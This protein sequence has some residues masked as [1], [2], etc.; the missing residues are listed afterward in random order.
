MRRFVNGKAKRQSS[1]PF[2]LGKR[3]DDFAQVHGFRRSATRPATASGFAG[4]EESA[5]ESSHTEAP[6]RGGSKKGLEKFGNW[7]GLAGTIAAIALLWRPARMWLVQ[8]VRRHHPAMAICTLV[9]FRGPAVAL[10]P[11]RI[12][13]CSA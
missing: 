4:Q 3:E 7:L 12:A 8:V 2:N 6:Q 1:H 11:A 10:Q 5:G 13:C 9:G